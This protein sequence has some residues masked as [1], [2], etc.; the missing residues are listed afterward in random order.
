MAVALSRKG[1]DGLSPTQ[2]VQTA[3]SLHMWKFSGEDVRL[4]EREK[5][6]GGTRPVFSFGLRE[7]ARQHLARLA[8]RPFARPH[9]NQFILQGGM[10]AFAA[11]MEANLP[12][13]QLVLT[14]DVPSH[15]LMLD[16]GRLDADGLLP[17]AVMKSTLYEPMAA[18]QLFK[19]KVPGKAHVLMPGVSSGYTSATDILNGSGWCEGRGIPPGAALSNLLAEAS[20]RRLLI[21]VEGAYEG[22]TAAAYGDNVIIL[23]NSVGAEGALITALHDAA[24]L[25]FGANAANV[26]QTRT[27]CSSPASG[28]RFMKSDWRLRGGKVVRRLLPGA[29][30]E[31]LNRVMQ[32]AYEDHLE[33]HR[34]KAK[35]AGWAGAR[36]YDPKAEL[37]A[38]D[39]YHLLGLSA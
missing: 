1:A 35:I 5:S 10:L 8:A 13:A 21:A 19:P 30:D 39:A 16:R 12:G 33:E 2:A 18:A 31:F 3:L 27:V 17:K 20:L 7:Y 14:T 28:F 24:L 34:L 37:I 26:V 29:A 25:E 4:E 6:D 32:A 23:A 22:V 38:A 36:A 9:P 11:W 15:F